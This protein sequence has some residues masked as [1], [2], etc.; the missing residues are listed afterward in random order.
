M[1]SGGADPDL[2]QY[3]ANMIDIV[4]P[5]GNEKEFIKMAER[6]GIEGLM[7]VYPDT[8][9]SP[10]PNLQVEDIASP[11]R[12]T[13]IHKT[14][15]D[16]LVSKLK[17][18]CVPRP[19]GRGVGHIHDISE[20]QKDTNLKI[21]VGVLCEPGK[22][23]KY[24]GKA[25]II[26]KAP[27]EQEK[28]RSVIE[29]DRPDILYGLEQGKRKDF[30]HHRASGLNHV[31]AELMAKNGVAMGVSFSD[32]LRATSWNRAVYIGRIK[33]NIKLARKFKFEVRI[34]SFGKSCWGLRPSYDANPAFET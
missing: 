29:Q 8:Q 2:F 26:I 24:R 16:V 23:R 28:I 12:P 13:L 10:H 19:L 1:Q 3:G 21:S 6:L 25:T 33:Q 18:F 34:G 9:N 7:F 20:F 27:E 14:S 22:A 15:E 31:L 17:E 11:G 5:N 30:L 32:I 4:F